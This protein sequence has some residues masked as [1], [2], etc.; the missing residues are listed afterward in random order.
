MISQQE[1]DQ[2]LVKEKAKFM[3]RIVR[4]ILKQPNL[5]LHLERKV[6]NSRKMME[7]K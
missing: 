7:K 3:E 1:E 5:N 2:K 4:R 6:N